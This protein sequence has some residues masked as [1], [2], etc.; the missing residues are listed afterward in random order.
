[1]A[2][3]LSDVKAQYEWAKAEIDF[4]IQDVI[5]SGY[6]IKGKWD[7]KFEDALATFYN[8]PYC[9]GIGSG[10]D[11]LEIIIDA[12]DIH[13]ADIIVPALTAAPT[14][15]AVIRTGNR[16]VFCDVDEDYTLS[17][18]SFRDAITPNTRAVIPVHLY[19]NPCK[20]AK[21]SDIARANG[22]EIIED[23]AQAIGAEV[24]KWGI[25]SAFSFFPAKNVGA[26]GDAGA[27]IT[28][29]EGIEYLCHTLANHGRKSKYQHL[30]IGRNSRLD[31]L[32]AAILCIKLNHLQVWTSIRRAFARLYSERLSIPY[33]P[34]SVYHQFVI[35][36]ENR[37]K[38]QKQLAQ[39]G[40]ETGI[41]YPLALPQQ[42]AF[43]DADAIQHCPNA[44]HYANR[45]LSLPMGI[46]LT[47]EDIYF[48]CGTL[49]SI[50]AQ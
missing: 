27:I 47:N 35:Q 37:E 20:M 1:M 43:W 16:A 3:G 22:L 4:A 13:G 18:K 19:G 39:A 10:T 21:I 12:L 41:H 26:F 5:S 14:A 31:E 38:I 6:F 24:G 48:V 15:E 30:F 8:V 44:C 28:R 11:A 32:Q 29:H 7:K 2:I 33:N 42:W 25:A 40:I 9:I 45:V 17:P 34:E 50:L 23:C 46:H 49:L 36:V